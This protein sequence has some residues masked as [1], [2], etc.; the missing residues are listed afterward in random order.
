MSTKKLLLVIAI[1]LIAISCGNKAKESAANDVE[2]AQTT[3]DWL[4]RYDRIEANELPDNIMQLIGEEWMLVTAGSKESLNTM[5]ASWGGMAYIWE[6]PS[7]LIFIRDT[8]YTYQLLQEKEDFTL[9]FF[10][11]DYRG[12]LKIC[13]SK[14]GRDTD[15][16]KEAGLTVIETPSGAMSFGEARM[17]IECKKT[18]VQELDYN[19][20]TEAYKEKIMEE[21]YN[22]EPS[23]HQM[24]ISEITNIW[25]KK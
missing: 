24:F 5:T 19:N 16:I 13:G 25:I 1:A 6:R 21:S 12:A 4:S 11:E 17:I 14:S 22:S 23:K 18:L 10:T 15:K 2:T 9:S 20:L 3:N 7:T 8:R